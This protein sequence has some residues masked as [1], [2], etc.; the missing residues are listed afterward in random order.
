MKETEAATVVAETAAQV[1]PALDRVNRFVAHES[2]RAPPPGCASRSS[3]AR[4][5]PRLNHEASRCLK[6]ASTLLSKG[7]SRRRSSSSLAHR[8]QAGRAMRGHVEA[9]EKFLARWLH[10]TDQ[11]RPGSPVDRCGRRLR[12][13]W[14]R[15]GSGP[16][17]SARVDEECGL[18][19]PGPVPRNAAGPHAPGRC[20]RPRRG[21]RSGAGKAR[22]A[23]PRISS[24]RR[25]SNSRPR[26]ATV[27]M[28]R[29]SHFT[30]ALPALHYWIHAACR[31]AQR[32]G[33]IR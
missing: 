21:R 33:P 18:V 6:S 14:I 3:A 4:R 15:S 25:P 7:C 16:K 29:S 9:S 27:S 28:M 2:S 11:V 24:S 31:S 17:C 1:V 10:R 12:L 8:H 26:S 20:W 32:A 13:A 23:G 19:V 22:A 30:P 5:K